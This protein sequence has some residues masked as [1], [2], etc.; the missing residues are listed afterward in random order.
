[1]R[2]ISKEAQEIA[3]RLLLLSNQDIGRYASGGYGQTKQ[4]EFQRDLRKVLNE[5]IDPPRKGL[6]A[7]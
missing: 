7:A 6:F 2:E 3:L 4:A 1:M 5:V